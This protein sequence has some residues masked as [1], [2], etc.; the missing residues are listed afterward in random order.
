MAPLEFAR[1]VS[2]DHALLPLPKDGYVQLGELARCSP[3]CGP[4]PPS[5]PTCC[6]SPSY[7]G[8]ITALWDQTCF[9]FADAPTPAVGSAESHVSLA[10]RVIAPPEAK[11]GHRPC[12]GSTGSVQ[13]AIDRTTGTEVA[14]KYISRNMMDT[15]TVLRE[16]RCRSPADRRLLACVDILA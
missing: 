3:T 15:K 9:K 7:R 6:T 1:G 14:I 13:L 16:V 2:A 4:P 10:Q 11:R 5:Q 12:R 8:C